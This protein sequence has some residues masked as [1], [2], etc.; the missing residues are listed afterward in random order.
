MTSASRKPKPTLHIRP[1]LADVDDGDEALREGLS[2]VS[3]ASHAQRATLA[4]VSEADGDGIS[5]QRA[6][7]A[8]PWSTSSAR[9]AIEALCEKGLAETDDGWPA[10]A[11]LTE[12]GERVVEALQEGGVDLA[13]EYLHTEQATET[14]TDTD[15]DTVETD[16]DDRSDEGDEETDSSPS[17][18]PS[19]LDKIAQRLGG[20]ETGGGD[21]ARSAPQG[22]Q[23]TNSST[24]S[25][26]G[27]QSYPERPAAE[28]DD[29]GDE[30]DDG[31]GGLSG[32]DVIATSIIELAASMSEKAN[33][34]AMSNL[35]REA[36]RAAQA[37]AYAELIQA[38]VALRE[39]RDDDSE[40]AAESD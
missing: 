26:R 33:Q 20:E 17:P 34:P 40:T 9:A 4:A 13:D 36:V 38:L 1:L 5:A 22:Q 19:S 37:S 15:A 30:D 18:S 27:A 3:S 7:G 8:I 29:D 32:D 21:F 12:T 10:L 25:S 23:S 28:W 24:A 14:D 39:S 11:S 31:E 35:H 16:E 2:W 6:G